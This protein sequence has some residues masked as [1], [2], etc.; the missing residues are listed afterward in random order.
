MKVFFLPAH[1]LIQFPSYF[2][3][4]GG[5]SG[6][7]LDL[8]ALD[9]NARVGRNGET[10]PHFTPIQ[11]L[12]ELVIRPCE[13]LLMSSLVGTVFS[14]LNAGGVYLKLGLVDPAF[15]RAQ[16]LFG[17]RRLFIQCFF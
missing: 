9:S 6:H 8:M 1:S 3:Q 4:F 17:A 15:I 14:R 10:L 2:F 5:A 7:T 12:F 16:R 13:N 11:S